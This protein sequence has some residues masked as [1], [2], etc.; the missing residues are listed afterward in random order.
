MLAIQSALIVALIATDGFF[1]FV[2]VFWDV[3]KTFE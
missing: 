1:V 3:P 2:F